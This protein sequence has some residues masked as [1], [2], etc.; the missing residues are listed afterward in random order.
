M[1]P[2]K[3]G[4]I[5][6]PHRAV[7]GPMAGFTDAPCRR[8]MAQHGAGFTVSEMVSSRALV[9]GDHKTV[10][11]L[12]A[13]PN[14]APYGVQIF[15]EV[16]EIMGEATAAIE[17]YEFDFVDINMGCPAPKIVS[18]GAGSKLMLDPDRC[19]R[20][21]EQVVAHTKRPVTVK[22]RKGWDADHITAVECAKACEQAGAALVA[23]HARTREQMYTPG[24][25]PDIIAKVKAAVKVPVL[26]NGD[27]HTAE[28]A[29]EMM[30]HTGCDG[31]MIARA[32]L[33]DPWLF[34]RANA[35][36]ETGICPALP[37]FAERIDTA[38]RQIELAAEQKGEHIAM[39]EARRHVNCYLKRESGVKTF[40]NR[41]C[42]L[43]K[44][45]DLYEIADEL[46]AFVSAKE[47]I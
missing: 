10:S 1:E 22:M 39:L 4:N 42:A 47:N 25:D 12:K 17:Q 20:I 31:V 23:V 45:S 37:P 33:G 6:L 2:L 46:K 43:T 27:I 16:P 24:I 29:V 34:E 19:G 38:V 26:G 11:L 9:Y 32:A 41:I 7:F 5:T 35:L 18:G 40:K 21:V 28:D 36:L 44:L 14:G 13:E 15:G 30:Q 8:L 3:I